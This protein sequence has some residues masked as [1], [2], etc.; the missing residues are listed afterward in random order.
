[1]H[2][3]IVDDDVLIRKW[4]TILLNQI[5]DQDMVIS[6]AGN[7]IQALQRIQSGDIPDLLIT[8]IKMPQMDGL[9]LC[10]QLRQSFP[11]IPIVILSAYDEFPFVKK[12]LQLGALDYVLK[13]DMRLEDIAAIIEK[14]KSYSRQGMARFSGQGY[15]ERNSQVL[16]TYLQSGV[17]DDNTFLLRLDAKFTLDSVSLMMLRLDQTIDGYLDV[18]MSGKNSTSAVL[19]PYCGT[20]YVA[21][22]GGDRLSSSASARKRE[23]LDFLDFMKQQQSFRVE[24]W[25]TVLN[26]HEIGI[27]SSIQTCWSVLNFKFYYGIETFDRIPYRESGEILIASQVPVYKRFFEVTSHYQIQ[28][29]VSLLRQCL[30][31]LHSIHCHPADIAKYISVM[32]HK[33]LSDMTLLEIGGDW[34]NQTLQRLHEVEQADTQKGREE[35]LEQFLAQYSNMVFSAAKKKSDAILQAVSYIDAHYTEKVTLEQIANQS[36]INNTYMSELF[37]KEMGVT[38]NDYINNLRIIHACEYLRFSNQSIGWIAEHSG[39]NDQNYFTK[40]FKKFLNITPSQY[41][42]KFMQ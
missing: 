42:A 11:N 6:V 9:T 32:C 35:A 37:K 10:Q 22:L 7:G 2:I 30:D 18:L 14:A 20:T 27:Y 40:V 23:T 39:F 19:I 4:L 8:D 13:A 34:F 3:L 25:A 5:P 1:M 33:L 16:T 38:L 24:A 15:A 36:H 17:K 12:A 41:R 29:A 31:S 21:F 28:E 26:C